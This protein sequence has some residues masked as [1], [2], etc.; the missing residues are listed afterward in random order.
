MQPA[1]LKNKKTRLLVVEDDATSVDILKIFLQDKYEIDTAANGSEALKKA[2]EFDYDCF[3]MDIGLPG[4]MNGVDVTKKLKEIRNNKN[5]PFIATTA[6][7]LK[8]DREH[9]LSQG[10]THC[11]IKPFSRKD[12][13]DIIAEALEG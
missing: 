12:L 1:N 9:F 3:L 4:K 2:R 7:A 13:M 8:S 5:K 6:Y 10:L 11:L